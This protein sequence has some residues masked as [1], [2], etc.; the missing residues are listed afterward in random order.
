MPERNIIPIIELDCNVLQKQIIG[1]V[2]VLN[3]LAQLSKACPAG[4]EAKY[5]HGHLRLYL[6]ISSEDGPGHKYLVR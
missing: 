4:T 3:L 5:Q 6:M 2:L 1:T